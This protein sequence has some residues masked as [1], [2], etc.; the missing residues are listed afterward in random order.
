MIISIEQ[1]QGKLI[2]SYVNKEGTTSY[3]QLN[4]PPAHQY[5]YTYAKSKAGSLSD[6]LSWDGKP[7]RKVPSNF[8]TKYRIQEF[9]EDAGESITAPL[10]EM[11]T[12]I[13][14][15]CDIEVNVDDDGFPEASDANSRINNIA[16][17]N[18]P[19]VICF[20]LK[21][22]TGEECDKIEKKINKHL[23][24]IHKEY[25]FI[26]K[27]YNSESDMLYDFL[28]NHARLT[29]LIAGW[30]F[31]N[32]DWQYIYNRCK[33]LNIDIS[34]MSPTKQWYKHRIMERNKK[35]E[36]MLPQHKLIVDYMAIYKKWDQV[37]NV[38]ENNSLDFAAETVLGIKKVKYSGSFQDLYKDYSE[39]V[40]Y[41]AI[42]TVLVEEIHYKINTMAIF[43]G[44]ANINR[45]EAMNAFSPISMLE[46]TATRY[47]Y[48]R[49]LV[50]PKSD[51]NRSRENYEGAFVFKPEPAMYNWLGVFDYQSM[52]PH[53]HM[54]FKI[55]F[56]NFIK[57]DK[58]YIPKKN[59]VTTISGAVFDNTVQPLLPEILTDY[60]KKRKEAQSLM[61]KAELESNMLKEILKKR[62][63]L[64]SSSL[65]K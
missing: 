6:I 2:V 31:W 32:Y 57:K 45:V 33:K 59:E 58:N 29:T 43:L 1:K 8:L 23:K 40:F 27:Q 41:N 62:E 48:K 53:L 46:A 30:N 63:K 44:L 50:F 3:M 56:E 42:D 11:N 22:L 14:H 51:Y 13:L 15:S 37:V 47:A 39:Y 21:P 9:F 65:N 18:Y 7:V 49:G 52:Y 20:G 28:Y 25:K 17:S 16:F 36:I 19:N 60:Y 24:P 61:K 38:K 34:W 35:S 12:P 55:S 4:I 10:F 54:Q 26:Y 5:I 64:V